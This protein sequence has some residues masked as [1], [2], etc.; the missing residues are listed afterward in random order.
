[1]LLFANQPAAAEARLRDAER[2]LQPGTPAEQARIIQGSVAEIRASLA[3]RVGDHGRALAL[4]RQALALLPE[5]ERAFRATATVLV[6]HVS[7]MGGD[8]TP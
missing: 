8:A 5:T 1:M 4:A 3:R 2:C 6:A 7:L